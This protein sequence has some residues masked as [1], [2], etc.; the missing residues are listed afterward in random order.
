VGQDYGKMVVI[1]GVYQGQPIPI[2]VD[3]QGRVIYL[4]APLLP[5]SIPA[6]FAGLT[7]P[8]GTASGLYCIIGGI[9]FFTMLIT[10]TSGTGTPST[11]LTQLPITPYAVD[12]LIFPAM[13]VWRASRYQQ[14]INQACLAYFESG[15]GLK[16]ENTGFPST[17]IPPN[18]IG[19]YLSGCYPTSV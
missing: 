12:Y 16:I 15:L 9:C 14:P 10:T 8:D 17:T 4:G 13:S 5:Y 18:I 3:A 1:E 2:L 7:P 11:A 6:T 19:I